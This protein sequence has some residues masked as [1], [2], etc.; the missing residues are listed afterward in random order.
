MGATAQA[1]SRT[2][3]LIAFAL[4]AL[5]ANASAGTTID[6][7]ALVREAQEAEAAEAAAAAVVAREEQLRRVAE[8][9][10]EAEA[11]RSASDG[12]DAAVTA[13]MAANDAQRQVEEAVDRLDEVN[14]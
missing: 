11:A 13:T 12:L 7:S 6:L 1:A 10:V 2:F 8:V 3:L 9:E 5:V 14:R 4:L